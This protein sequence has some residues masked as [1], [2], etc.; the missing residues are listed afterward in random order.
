MAHDENQLPVNPRQLN[1][2][3]P[4]WNGVDYA[5]L[6]GALR[7]SRRISLFVPALPQGM[8]ALWTYRSEME[9]KCK[10]E[11]FSGSEQF[12]KF[13]DLSVQAVNEEAQ[14]QGIANVDPG[15]MIFIAD[16][17]EE[18]LNAKKNT[19]KLEKHYTQD[20]NLIAKLQNVR[21]QVRGVAGNIPATNFF[22]DKDARKIAFEA[23]IKELESGGRCCTLE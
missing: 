18:Y 15:K 1:P 3:A 2:K 4:V 11:G 14:A 6:H 16:K 20:A 22:T 12:A 23:A 8:A 5:S 17:I 10:G 19:L 7:S 13:L 21:N 9:K